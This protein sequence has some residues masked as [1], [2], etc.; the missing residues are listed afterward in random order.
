MEQKEV[1]RNS[2][3]T[4]LHPYLLN[5]IICFFSFLLQKSFGFLHNILENFHVFQCICCFQWMV[6]IF[7]SIHWHLLFLGKSLYFRNNTPWIWSSDKGNGIS[8]SKIVCVFQWCR[9]FIGSD[10]R[11]P[12]TATFL[13]KAKNTDP[14]R[15][16]RWACLWTGM[17][18]P[19]LSS[20]FLG[21]QTNRHPWNH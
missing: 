10:P 11:V 6:C 21:I 12:K 13:E 3:L 4:L 20:S 17:G 8:V 18:F 16:F 9:Y 1:S 15:S 14:T 5:M 7:I 19:L 2:F